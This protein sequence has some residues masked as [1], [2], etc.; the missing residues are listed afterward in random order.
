MGQLRALP[1]VIPPI[2]VQQRFVERASAIEGLRAKAETARTRLDELFASLQH[3]AF[4][5]ELILG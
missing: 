2:K 3:Q 4:N 5:G 1:V